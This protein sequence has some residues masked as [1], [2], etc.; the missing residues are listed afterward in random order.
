LR[1]LWKTSRDFIAQ[2]QLPLDANKWNVFCADFRKGQGKPVC[3]V[4]S[5]KLIGAFVVGVALFQSSITYGQKAPQIPSQIVM[6]GPI[7]LSGPYAKEGSQGLW[8]FQ[9][10]EKWIN[11]VNG[12]VRLDG[13][14][15]RSNTSTTMCSTGGAA[16]VSAYQNFVFC[17]HFYELNNC[18][19]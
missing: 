9:V 11:E 5:I 19:L 1:N 7:S 8:G 13:K 4:T 2:I 3:K 18:Y 14:R 16:G 15:S 12:G 17:F 10:A 6:G